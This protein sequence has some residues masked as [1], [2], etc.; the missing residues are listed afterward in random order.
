MGLSKAVVSRR[1][2][3]IKF[4]FFDSLE[5]LFYL[6]LWQALSDYVLGLPSFDKL[7]HWNLVDD[8][9]VPRSDVGQTRVSLEA[10]I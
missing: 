2:H 6:L 3:F 5:D 7:R 4:P 1:I 10:S 9:S 8:I